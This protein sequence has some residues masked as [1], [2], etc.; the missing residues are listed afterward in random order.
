MKQLNQTAGLLQTDSIEVADTANTEFYKRFPYPWPPMKFSYLTDPDFET[1]MLNQS[2]G[3]WQQRTIP[4]HP[5]IWIAGCGTNQAI[6]TALRFPNARIIA[7]D[8]SRNALDI[9]A[10]IAK[11]LQIS[12]LEL[13]E[14]SINQA[15]YVEAFDYIICTGVIHHNTDPAAS[16]KKIATAL[17]PNGVLEVMVYNE[18]HRVTIRAFQKAIR[19][20]TQDEKTHERNFE[21]ELAI[22]RALVMHATTE[23]SL[24]D[25]LLEYRDC[26]EPMLA[27]TL[28]Q[29]IEHYYTVESMETLL[30]QCG[31]RL[32]APYLNPFDKAS[33][34]FSWNIEF[35]DSKLQHQYDQ[36]PDSRRWQVTNYLKLN[37]SP[38]LWFYVQRKDNVA[39]RKTEQQICEEFLATRFV[40]PTTTQRSFILT[41]QSSHMYELSAKEIPFPATPEERSLRRIY[42]NFD[43]E[44]TAQENLNRLGVKTTFHIVNQF[45]LKLTTSLFP[46]LQAVS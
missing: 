37:H 9:S 8:L 38:M 1:V 27:D 31:L 39:P 36:L 13:R 40:K 41:P 22:A 43:P 5:D 25:S 28:L 20:L 42:D 15:T 6:F 46:Y 17:K 19:L 14:E 10:T 7:S 18:Y 23:I 12:N 2:I 21:Q 4:R 30:D 16:L 29:P 26:P 32:Q 33:S 34:T 45:R 3:D 44:K 35:E 11:E 24:Y